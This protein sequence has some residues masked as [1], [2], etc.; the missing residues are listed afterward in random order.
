MTGP[1]RSPAPPRVALWELTWRCDLA[2][3]HCLVSGGAPA[4]DELDGPTALGVVEQIADLGV[5]AV[6]LTGG[7]PLLRPDWAEIAASVRERGMVMRLSTHGHHV[8]DA[9]VERLIALGTDAVVVSVDGLQGTHD[10]RRSG[11]G[12]GRSSFQL[13][14]DLL[15]RLRQTP[16]RASVITTV[17]RDNLDELEILRDGLVA[18][19]VQTWQVQIAHRT[20]RAR[21][22][23]GP[24]LLRPS[25]LPRLA[26][27][28]VRLAGDP[29]LPPRVH[30]SIGYLSPEEPLLRGS[31]RG[32]VPRF[33]Q[34]CRCGVTR[35]GIEPDGG[36][37][38]CA[39]QIGAPFVVGSL[40]EETLRRIWE[41]RAR[42]HWLAAPPAAPVGSCAGCALFP[43]CRAGCKALAFASSGDLFDNPYCLRA[44]RR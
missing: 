28:L 40:R 10:R 15:L 26:G 3:P 16:I 34:G 13:V 21:A 4:G 32:P 42:W 36:V 27:I 37:K 7:E 29:L 33:W 6:T 17:A 39:S 35:I 25:D 38:G 20:G 11:G 8:D 18:L 23:G 14:C 1:P 2:C 5:R 41:D 12:R 44:V 43:V 22:G 19:G 9:V 30:N 31:G 24:P